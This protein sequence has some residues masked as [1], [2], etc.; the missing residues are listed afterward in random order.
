LR[1]FAVAVAVL[2]IAPPVLCGASGMYHGARR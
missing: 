2:V 1:A